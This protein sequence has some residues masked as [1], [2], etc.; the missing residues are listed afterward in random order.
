MSRGPRATP[1]LTFARRAVA[2]QFN[3]NDVLTFE[4]PSLRSA[5]KLIRV[6][7]NAGLQSLAF[8][9][10]ELYNDMTILSNDDLE[11]C[12]VRTR[13]RGGIARRL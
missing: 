6:V 9:A 5:S 4:V 12:A 10:L 2:L 13:A 8:D 7:A 3:A 1:R 11:R